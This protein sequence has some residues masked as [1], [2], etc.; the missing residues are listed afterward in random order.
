MTENKSPATPSKKAKE[1]ASETATPYVMMD[2]FVHANGT[3]MEAFMRAGEAVLKGVGTLGEEMVTFAEKRVRAS[4]D[5]TQSLVRCGS[6]AEAFELQSQYARSATEEYFT[7]ATKIFSLSAK[8]AKDGMAPIE[9]QAR[10]AAE[11]LGK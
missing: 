11:N 2:D 4:M 3:A 6:F 5:T 7:E 9:S 1:T 10:E 8:I